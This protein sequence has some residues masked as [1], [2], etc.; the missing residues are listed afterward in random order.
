MTIS[1]SPIKNIV[2]NPQN[3]IITLENGDR[4]SIEFKDE[5]FNIP[6]SLVIKEHKD[7]IF[8]KLIGK[9]MIDIILFNKHTFRYLSDRK[10]V[11]H[12][13]NVYKAFSEYPSICEISIFNGEPFYFSIEY[14]SELIFLYECI[15]KLNYY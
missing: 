11:K 15:K 6:Q 1:N 9:T 2:K 8:K 4:Y 7:F 13:N 12:I 10:L 5:R 3:L 14:D